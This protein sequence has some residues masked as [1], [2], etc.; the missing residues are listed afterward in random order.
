MEIIDK[1]HNKL[2][3]AIDLFIAWIVANVIK[4]VKCLVPKRWHRIAVALE[5]HQQALQNVF[6]LTGLNALGGFLMLL[7]QVKLANALGA[8]MY[9]VYSYCLAIGEVGAMIVRYGRNK[10]MTRDLIQRP[11]RRTFL[12]VNTFMLSA[13]NFLVFT[14]CVVLLHGQLD[15]ELNAAY[16]LL[17]MAP[18]I[19]SMD[20]LPVYESMWLMGWHS[21]YYLIQRVLFLVA[22]WCLIVLYGSP[23][24]L[25]LGVIL[26]LSWLIVMGL[27]FHEVRL[28]ITEPLLKLVSA[29]NILFL[30]KE[31]F[32]IAMSCLFGVAFGPLI[33]LILKQY[34]DT[35]SVGIYS[36]GMQIFLI[37]Q[38]ILH[39]VGRVGNPMM[40]ELGKEDCSVSKRRIFVNRYLFTMIASTIPFAL[41]MLFFPRLITNLFFT[42]EYTELANYLP[43]LALYL[44]ALAIGAVF[45][46]F[47]IS[48]RKDKIY[49][50]I[51]VADSLLTTATA[52]YAIPH[53]GVLGAFLSLCV[54]HGAAHISYAIASIKYLHK[55]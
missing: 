13:V 16:L 26:F 37:S 36:A 22:V 48:I 45:T 2:L 33:R 28:T 4:A 9:G 5:N 44:I 15:I 52:Y 6:G 25:S 27:Q 20:F 53:W 50:T 19:V 14:L 1:K 41:P 8:S 35:A 32:V 11:N 24:L 30:Y 51:Y 10:T 46:Q 40:A 3:Y 7:T 47:L 54:P 23:S 38:F 12:I 31:N 39:Q 18:C 43:I 21:I 55:K 42:A 29:K 49:F 34:T 17:I